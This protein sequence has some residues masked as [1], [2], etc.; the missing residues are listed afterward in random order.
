M[1]KL[2]YLPVL[3][4][5]FLV[6]AFTTFCSCSSPPKPDAV[7]LKLLILST[8][9]CFIRRVCA[10]LGSACMPFSCPLAWTAG[11]LHYDVEELNG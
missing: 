10:A 8:F 5:G 1:G 9:Y 4:L 3:S 2:I 6:F 11:G 7:K